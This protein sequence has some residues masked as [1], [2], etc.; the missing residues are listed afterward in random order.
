MLYHILEQT[1]FLMVLKSQRYWSYTWTL[2]Y[3]TFPMNCT[4]ASHNAGSRHYGSSSLLLHSPPGSLD[5]VHPLRDP[6]ALCVY[7]RTLVIPH[8][9]PKFWHRF[10][11]IL[12]TT[13]VTVYYDLEQHWAQGRKWFLGTECLEVSVCMSAGTHKASPRKSTLTVP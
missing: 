7:I 13:A 9:F 6:L 3:H 2:A 11:Q 12:S 10:S 4:S 1:E 5:W 8:W